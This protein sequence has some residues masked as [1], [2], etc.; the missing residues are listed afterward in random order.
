[1]E[2]KAKQIALEIDGIDYTLEYNR[3]SIKKMEARGFS[4]ADTK[5]KLV[6]NLDLLVE[7]AFMKN[8][9]TLK[10]KRMEEIREHMY[11]NY[12]MEAMMEVLV[13]MIEGAIPN[14]SDNKNP[15]KVFTVVRG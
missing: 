13:E 12:D 3:D 5:E 14:F 9:P 15:K 11:E 2:Q 4:L 10:P 6:T 7:G 1:M 8:H